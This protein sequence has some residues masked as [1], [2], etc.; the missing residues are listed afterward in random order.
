LE[1]SAVYGRKIIL[2][3]VI[4]WTSMRREVC[5]SHPRELE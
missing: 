5:G 3:R 4:K 1:S 2:E